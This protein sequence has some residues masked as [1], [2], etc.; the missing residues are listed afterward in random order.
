MLAVHLEGKGRGGG[1]YQNAEFEAIGRHA[2]INSIGQEHVCLAPPEN[3]YSNFG[4]CFSDE[5]IL[6]LILIKI[7]SDGQVSPC[8][9]RRLFRFLC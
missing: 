8:K 9:A 1:L 5:N 6:L 7:L 4:G 3:L 2:V